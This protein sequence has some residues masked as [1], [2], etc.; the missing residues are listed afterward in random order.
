MSSKELPAL[1]FD[2]LLFDLFWL[3]SLK[4]EREWCVTRDVPMYLAPTSKDDKKLYCSSPS[5]VR[6]S[7]VCMTRRK[8]SNCPKSRLKPKN[9]DRVHGS[10]A[11]N[12]YSTSIP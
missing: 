3:P 8:R 2:T 11:E 10:Q 12:L 9:L 1:I 6:Y 5:R 7:C 4:L